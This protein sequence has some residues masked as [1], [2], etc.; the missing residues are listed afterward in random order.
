MT[1]KERLLDFLKTHSINPLESWQFLGIYRLSAIIFILRKE[2]HN[3]TT[4]M[5]EVGNMYG[6]MCRVARYEL[7]TDLTK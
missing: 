6:E 3:I 4:E 7:E 2:G 1:Q 5:E